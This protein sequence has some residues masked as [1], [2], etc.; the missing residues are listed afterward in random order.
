MGTSRSIVIFGGSGF[1]GSHFAQYVLRKKI[2]ETVTLVD[3]GAPRDESYTSLVQSGLQSGVVKFIRWDVRQKIPPELVAERPELIANFAAVHREPGH[4]PKEY[5]ETNING[6]NNICLYASQV[7]CSR[8]IFLSS[9]SPYGRA[10]EMRDETSLPVPDTPYGSSKLVA[11]MVHKEWQ[12][13]CSKRKILI[14]R[15]GVVFG[16]GENGN[17]TRLIKSVS[18]GYFVYMGNRNIRKAGGYVK[19]LCSVIEFGLNYQEDKGESSTVLNFSMDPPPTLEDYV[20]AIKKVIG[21]TGHPVSLPR[22]VVL[23]TSYLAEGIARVLRVRQPLNPTRVRKLFRSTQIDPRRLREI[24]Y[25]WKFG[26]LEALLDWKEESPG[27]FHR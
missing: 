6:A 3:L 17:V 18:G 11:E 1:I 26:L 4:L 5:F 19:E 23:G 25:R 7:D 9:I 15:P 8:I 21:R 13:A 24:E 12:A 10:D 20:E 27:D 14:I 22:S 2:V 16:P